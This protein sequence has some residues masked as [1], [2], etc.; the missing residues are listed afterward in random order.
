MPILHSK[1]GV[2]VLS[3]YKKVITLKSKRENRYEKDQ[4]KLTKLY[5]Q[6]YQETLEQLPKLL[7]WIAQIS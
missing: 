2:V 7:E 1:K 6:G 3:F 5:N 4:T